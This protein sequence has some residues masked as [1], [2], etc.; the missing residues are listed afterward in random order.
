[1]MRLSELRPQYLA[2]LRYERYCAPQTIKAY[3]NDFDALRAAVGDVEPAQISLAD[4]RGLVRGWAED[5]RAAATIR[6]RIHSLGTLWYWF[7]LEGQAGDNLAHRLRPPKRRQ[8]TPHYLTVAQ[9]EQLLSTPGPHLLAWQIAAYAGLR[10]GELLALRWD[11]VMED[12]ELIVVRQ[13]KGRKDRLI[14]IP[15]TLAQ[16]LRQARPQAQ[17]A[18]VLMVS[19]DAITKAFQAH[20]EAAG[21]ADG[22]T[23]LHTLRHSYATHLVQ[24]GAHIAS[25][26]ELLGHRDLATTLIYIHHAPD[27]LRAAVKKHPLYK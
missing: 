17:G 27:D 12:D 9:L 22:R 3:S 20:L 1:M 21:L 14:P 10:R 13:G 19:K 23:T 7:G 24:G 11:D 15:P 4:L 16:A 5:G 18:R 25:V 2:Y 26:R 6:R 8:A